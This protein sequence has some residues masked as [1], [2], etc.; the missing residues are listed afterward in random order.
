MDDPRYRA[1]L[2]K[3]LIA[4]TLAP[5][6]ETMLW[7]YSKGK[8]KDRVEFGADKSLAQLCIEAINGTPDQPV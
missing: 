6:V 2:K 1:A 8:P 5:A 4:G 3:R 7:F